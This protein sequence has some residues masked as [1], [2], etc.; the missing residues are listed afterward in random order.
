MKKVEIERMQR[1]EEIVDRQTDQISKLQDLLAQERTKSIKLE[2]AN[3]ALTDLLI[4]LKEGP[5]QVTK[6][7]E[8]LLTEARR[9][10]ERKTYAR[11]TLNSDG[12]ASNQENQ[13]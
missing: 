10:V 13:G 3:E 4:R 5:I 8:D 1:L 7:M 9:D 12:N 2:G 6:T 11:L